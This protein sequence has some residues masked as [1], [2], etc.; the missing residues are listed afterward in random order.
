[1]TSSEQNHD[2][3]SVI[4]LIRLGYEGRS[5]KQSVSLDPDNDSLINNLTW[6]MKSGNKILIVT[7]NRNPLFWISHGALLC[8]EGTVYIY[9]YT[10]IY[11]S[12]SVS[13][14]IESRDNICSARS[15]GNVSEAA[16]SRSS[17]TGSWHG[18]PCPC[19]KIKHL[20]QTLQQYKV[21]KLNNKHTWNRRM[22][23]WFNYILT[24]PQWKH[25]NQQEVIK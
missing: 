7:F 15:G 22:T 18:A 23:K 8:Q 2:I 12:W 19:F 10:H 11:I 4:I 14:M 3:T 13:T 20:V 16:Q 25:T 5:V 9:I 21:R 17:Q 1:M 6:S 24:K